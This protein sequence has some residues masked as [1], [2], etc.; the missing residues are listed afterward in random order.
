MNELQSLERIIVLRAADA[1]EKISMN[2]EELLQPYKQILLKFLDGAKNKELKWHIAQLIPRLHLSKSETEKAFDKL[3]QWAMDNKESR[4]VR[5][6][7][8]QALFEFCCLFSQFKPSFE[9]I[10]K[11]LDNKNIPSITARIKILR[12][13]NSF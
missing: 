1:I 2:K 7:S 3:R 5:V 11:E 8:I 12:K 9:L 13:Q 4:I 6:N 10:L